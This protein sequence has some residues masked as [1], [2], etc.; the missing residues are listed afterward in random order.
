VSYVVSEMRMGVV[1]KKVNGPWH[2]Y[3][4]MCNQ[5][6]GMSMRVCVRDCPTWLSL[7][8]AASVMPSTATST[9]APSCTHPNTQTRTHVVSSCFGQT[10]SDG[11]LTS[12]VSCSI[13]CEQ[14]VC[15]CEY[16]CV[17]ASDL[18]LPLR[19]ALAEAQGDQSPVRRVAQAPRSALQ[20]H[21][22]PADTHIID[23]I[24]NT[25]PP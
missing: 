2:V 5:D 14:C 13:L 19:G 22:L 6:H 10:H 8:D 18:P 23:T 17:C 16:A 21:D 1:V 25:A 20:A 11:T 3:A 24:S 4:C 9:T 15:V 7:S 12:S